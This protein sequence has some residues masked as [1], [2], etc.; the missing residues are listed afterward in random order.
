MEMADSW[1]AG[2]RSGLDQQ[3]LSAKDGRTWK[4]VGRREGGFGMAVSARVTTFEGKAH[5][6]DKLRKAA[7]G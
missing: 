7:L 1:R 2:N 5:K 3:R 6:R 4:G